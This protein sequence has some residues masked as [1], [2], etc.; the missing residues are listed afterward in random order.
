MDGNH[1]LVRNRCNLNL[2]EEYAILRRVGD[3]GLQRRLVTIGTYGSYIN[4]YLSRAIAVFNQTNEEYYVHLTETENTDAAGIAFTDSADFDTIS[5][6]A[7]RGELP[8]LQIFAQD[9]L[10]MD[11]DDLYTRL[12]DHG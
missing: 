5:A 1:L 11:G 4:T 2:T 10:S 8:D 9:F 6:L 3:E 7:A 12:V